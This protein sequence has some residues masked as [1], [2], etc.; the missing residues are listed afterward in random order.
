M[1][2]GK[3]KYLSQGEIDARNAG[4]SPYST[5]TWRAWEYW[6]NKAGCGHMLTR[7]DGGPCTCMTISTSIRSRVVPRTGPA[8]EGAFDRQCHM[9]R[10]MGPASRG[11]RR[12]EYNM[13]LASYIAD[14]KPAYGVVT[15]DGVITMNE[16]FGGQHATLREA[17]AG[18]ALAADPR[19]RRAWAR[20]PTTSCPRS[21][22]CRRSRTR[23][24]SSASASTTNRTPPSTAPRRRSCRTSSRASSTRWCAHEGEMIR[25]KVS[26][27]FDFEGELALVIGKGGRHIKRGG[28]ALSRRRLHLLLRRHRA[29]FH[30]IFA[31]RQQELHRHRPARPLDGDRRRNP[32]SDQAHADDAAQRRRRCSSPAP[33]C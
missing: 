24:R 10:R 11:R 12:A 4:Y 14:G 2:G 6:A 5:E 7:P 33:T 18:G 22:S 29:R 30:Q 3:I 13:K 20:R 28:R 21:S 1:L 9:R 16:R 25:P 15:G 23:K 27:N 32:R 8:S 19:R 31:G 17:L 26:T